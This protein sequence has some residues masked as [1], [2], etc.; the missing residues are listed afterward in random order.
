MAKYINLNIVDEV[1][2]WMCTTNLQN[3]TYE[4]NDLSRLMTTP[5]LT[6][7]M[8]LADPVPRL[9]CLVLV[10][11]VYIGKWFKSSVIGVAR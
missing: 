9:A 8:Q 7:S 5:N 1:P 2:L 10:M 3:V 11:H 4:F 6:I